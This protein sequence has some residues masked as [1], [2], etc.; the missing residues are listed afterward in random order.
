MSVIHHIE[1][2]WFVTNKSKDGS[3]K[4]NDIDICFDKL[5]KIDSLPN[6]LVMFIL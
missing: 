5:L 6:F 2:K 4:Q 3:N 1:M